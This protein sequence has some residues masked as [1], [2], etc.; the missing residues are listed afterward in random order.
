MRQEGHSFSEKFVAYRR[1]RKPTLRYVR[2]SY[3]PKERERDRERDAGVS[4]LL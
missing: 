2:S 3:R 1:D 4:P